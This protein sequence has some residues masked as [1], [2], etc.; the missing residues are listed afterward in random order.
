MKT[1]IIISSSKII[2]E[3]QK[4]RRKDRTINMYAND[5]QWMT[6]RLKWKLLIT[7]LAH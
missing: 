5:M 3:V 2:H 1:S 4:D 6:C 7:C